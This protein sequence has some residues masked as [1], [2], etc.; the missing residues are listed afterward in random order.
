[1]RA[2]PVDE[3]HRVASPLELLFDLVFVVAISLLAS[4]LAHGIETGHAVA[5]TG[6]YLLVFFAIWWAWMNFT[7]FA[8]AYDTDDVPYRLL[9]L[10]QMGGVLV[11]AA[12]VPAAF[13]HVDFVAVTV[14]YAIMRVALMAQWIRAAVEHPAG[15]ATAVR[16]AVGVGLVQVGW[17]LRLLLPDVWAFSASV[18][19]ALLEVCVPLWAERRGVTSWHAHHIAERYGLFVLIMLGESV[20]AATN[21]VAA[22]LGE[23]G[24]SAEL[25]AVA[26]AGLVVLFALWWLYFLEPVASALERHR[27]LAF[28]WGYGHYVLFAAVAAVGAGLDVVVHA[29]GSGE[30]DGSGAS[31]AAFALAVPVAVLLVVHR[32]LHAPLVGGVGVSIMTG[33]AAVLVLGAAG[34]APVL[35]VAGASIGVAVVLAAL[36]AARVAIGARSSRE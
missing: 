1:M 35:G 24:L 31:E 22:V 13:E 26:V 4:Q 11:L 28:F 25:L 36:V 12:G 27:S 18:L 34:A 23:D 2:R 10:V 15:R 29:A 7:W 14:G 3:A 32:I 5:S 17:I 33:V 16:Y 21:A 30:G 6:S 19:L 8:S 20:L 9:T